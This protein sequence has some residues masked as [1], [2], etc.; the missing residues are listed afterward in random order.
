[1]ER[2]HICQWPT[3]DFAALNPD[4]EIATRF[5]GDRACQKWMDLAQEKLRRYVSQA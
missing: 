5:P 3:L 4:G 2:C 1:M